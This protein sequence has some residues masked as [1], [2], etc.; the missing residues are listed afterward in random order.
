MGNDVV[1]SVDFQGADPRVNLET[2]VGR[3]FDQKTVDDDVQHLWKLGRFDDISVKTRS[4]PDGT[5]VIFDLK[6]AVGPR[7]RQVHVEPSSVGLNV[8][9][10]EGTVL[11]AREAHEIAGQAQRE[12]VAAGY[13]DAQVSYS[14]QPATEHLADLKLTVDEGTAQ[15][16][17]HTS[18]SG[19]PVFTD[20]E[21][22]RQ[23]HALQPRQVMLFWHMAPLYS[24]EAAKSDAARLE[25]FYVS[26]GYYDA[27][28]EPV[29]DAA[30]LTFA[31][32]PG[33]HYEG[34]TI[35]CNALLASRRES[36]RV[37]VLDFSARVNVTTSDGRAQLETIT[38][39]G[40]RY[41]VGQINFVGNHHYSGKAIRSYFV[42]QEAAPFDEYLLRKSLARVNRAGWFEP[43]TEN[44]VAIFPH[45]Q[46]G[47]ADVTIRFTEKKRGKWS[48]SGPVGTVSMGGPL[49]ASVSLR[50]AN[51]VL[52][53]S[54][55]ALEPAILPT[56]PVK[57]LIYLAGIQR[58]GT[59]WLSGISLAPQLGWQFAV[60]TYAMTQ[61]RQ[62]L[63]PVLE[64]NR[65]LIPDLPVTV[66]TPT[67]E[68]PLLCQAPQPR[69]WTE[70]RV[71]IFALQM[72]GSF[73]LL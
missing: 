41:T 23:L 16:L 44:D 60:M 2:Q 4:Q 71:A 36:E 30:R 52:S 53:I 57:P 43:V 20:K 48:F 70:R 73:P 59:G 6:P 33:P 72:S 49:E 9:V 61:L 38:K 31:I 1:S 29:G 17:K 63:T 14:I 67:G 15:K 64:G 11:D 27:T 8:S 13:R 56:I 3:P 19:D 24:D 42:L 46:T 54:L 35:D 65:N 68:K 26:R 58:S 39:P 66:E 25:S 45:P 18:F 47:I 69:M 40:Q 12:L 22:R 62:R 21:L 28:V 10:P 51:Y 50:V 5:A 37:G 7:L 55:V 34:P 32:N